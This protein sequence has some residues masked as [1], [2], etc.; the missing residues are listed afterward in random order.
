M[1]TGWGITGGGHGFVDSNEFTGRVTGE[2]RGEGMGIEVTV[3]G[4]GVRFGPL[5]RQGSGRG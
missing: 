2:V 4:G 5:M 1:V 3:K